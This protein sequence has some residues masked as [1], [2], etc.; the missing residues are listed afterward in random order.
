MYVYLWTRDDVS[1]Q[2]F[3]EYLI[4]AHVDIYNYVALARA[5]VG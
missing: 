5:T 1:S 4:L 2:L 3:D